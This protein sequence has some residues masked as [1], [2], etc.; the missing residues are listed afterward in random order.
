VKLF[1][2]VTKSHLTELKAAQYAREQTSGDAVT[3]SRP[4]GRRI[5]VF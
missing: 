4:I 1:V 5:G 3:N 2:S